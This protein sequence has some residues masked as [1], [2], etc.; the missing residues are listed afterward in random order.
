MIKSIA[1][2]ILVSI[3]ISSPISAAPERYPTNS[4]I[5]SLRQQFRQ[6]IV[7]MKSDKVRGAYIK[8]KRSDLERQARNSFVESWSKVDPS[9]A[10]FIGSWIGDGY[11]YHIYPS[12]KLRQ[13]CIIGTDEGQASFTTGTIS[14]GNI[15]T[16]DR[17]VL[18]REST[19]LGRIYI[20]KGKLQMTEIP[21]KSPSSP[22]S[23][24]ELIKYVAEETEK[25]SI[26][27]SFRENDCISSFTN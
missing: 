23:L 6:L 3:L 27:Q 1:S 17:M 19:Y 25:N 7:K 5:K 18:F 22:K 9:I 8:D 12:K 4:E 24:T 14:N 16:K 2:V 10:P 26:S 13:V 15:F 11:Y 21:F 20:Y